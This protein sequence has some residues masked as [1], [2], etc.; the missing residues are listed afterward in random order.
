MK[1]RAGGGG[2]EEGT[3]GGLTLT[4]SGPGSAGRCSRG[5]GRGHSMSVRMSMSS[6]RVGAGRGNGTRGW[7]VGRTHAR[8]AGST[9]DGSSTARLHGG[10]GGA[11]INAATTRGGAAHRLVRVI[12]SSPVATAGL[13]LGASTYVVGGQHQQRRRPRDGGSSS[14]FNTS[15]DPNRLCTDALLW[16]NGIGYALQLLTGH[17]VTAMGAK[18]NAKIAAGQLWRLVTPLALHGSVVHLL[19]NCYS[20]HNIGPVIERQFGREQFLITYVGAGI[21]GNLLS[22]KMSPNNAVGAS[23]AIFGLV[24]ALGV[25]LH[26]HSELF[27]AYGERQLQSLMGSIGANALFGLMSSRIDNWAHLGGLLAGGAVAF[28]TGPN[29]MVVS[30]TDGRT[31]QWPSSTEEGAR[32]V[33]VRGRTVVNRPMLQTYVSEFVRE[34]RDDDDDDDE[35]EDDGRGGGGRAKMNR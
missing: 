25:Y 7:R 22:Y 23:G 33:G 10:G 24:G 28:L 29:L 17:A 35:D 1:K 2:G 31:R 5:R 6:R 4:S 16:G 32:R 19:V 13:T 20:L 14:N 15:G 30:P 12:A 18:V 21:G 26:R 8:T 34:F 11:G 9:S 3:G 27:G